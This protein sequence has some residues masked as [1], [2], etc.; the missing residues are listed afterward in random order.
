MR[1]AARLA[2]LAGWGLAL[3][4]SLTGCFAKVQDLPR[5]A[6]PVFA[7]VPESDPE[8]LVGLAISG[9]GSRAATFAA[10]VLE[11]LARVRVPDGAGGERSVLERG[12]YM[13][14]VAGGTRAPGR[15]RA[16][17]PAAPPAGPRARPR[18]PLARLRG[19][20]P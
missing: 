14:S 7:R 4:L 10:A 17:N 6:T 8:L 18:R 1:A 11:A 2:R 9:G 15:F 19:L 20:L 16:R 13:S 12:Q 3:T 5:A